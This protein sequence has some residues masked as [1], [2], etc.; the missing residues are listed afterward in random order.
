MIEFIFSFT[1]LLASVIDM[2]IGVIKGRAPIA[3]S[4][5]GLKSL[6]GNAACQFC[7]KKENCARK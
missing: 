6:N 2:A 4:C 1:I 3:G 7:G 5:G